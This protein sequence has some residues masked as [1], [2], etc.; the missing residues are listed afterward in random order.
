MNTEKTILIVD[1]DPSFSRTLADILE[2]EGFLVTTVTQGIKALAWVE[3]KTTD[4]A[5]V[6]LKLNDLPGLDVIAGIIKRS[7]KTKC[8]VL[9]GFASQ[10]SYKNALDLGVISYIE[11]PYNVEELLSTIRKAT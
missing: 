9:T 8:I 2:V 5:I 7:P 4:V 10:T 1:D 3:E 6:D 11:K